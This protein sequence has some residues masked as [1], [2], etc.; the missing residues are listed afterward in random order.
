MRQEID[1]E[2]ALGEVLTGPRPWYNGAA[3]GELPYAVQIGSGDCL[4]AGEDFP[5]ALVEGRELIYG[6]D[7]R[8]FVRPRED[9]PQILQDIDIDDLGVLVV[10]AQI[11]DWQYRDASKITP[12]IVAWLGS[13]V[14]VTIAPNT[15]GLLPGSV[16]VQ[17]PTMTLVFVA[18]TTS[19]QQLATQIMQATFSLRDTGQY[20]TLPLWDDAQASLHERVLAAGVDP[21]RPFILVGHSYGGA[22]ATLLA[23][24]Y[25]SADPGRV[26]RLVTF[27]MPKPGDNRVR[28]RLGSMPRVHVVN[29]DD[30][31][32]SIPP[33]VGLLAYLA[34]LLPTTILQRWAV[35]R[36]VG[37]QRVLQADGTLTTSQAPTVDFPQLAGIIASLVARQPLQFFRGHDMSEYL[38]RLRIGYT[39]PRYPVPSPVR[40]DL[41]DSHLMDWKDIAE[42]RLGGDDP[43]T[44][45][46]LIGGQLARSAPSDTG[47]VKIDG[48][49]QDAAPPIAGGVEI[50]A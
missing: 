10:F 14:T 39:V 4:S 26:I 31:V 21:S 37:Q 36:N 44:A 34:G 16:I 24:R 11:L 45:D 30:P 47:G 2:P 17:T 8:C 20:T 6:I 40:H 25:Q 3:P 12:L 18:G 9:S 49:T 41:V 27:G 50:G 32:G 22:V 43:A 7:A 19:P 46:L 29:Y 5:P 48:N 1:Y 33:D 38:R 23:A 28:S 15:D 35:M 42:L 13:A